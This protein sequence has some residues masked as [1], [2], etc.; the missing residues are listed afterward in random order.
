MRLCTCPIPG[1]CLELNVV[2]FSCGPKRP[3]WVVGLALVSPPATTVSTAD[4]FAFYQ[5]NGV[6][7]M[8]QA[9]VANGLTGVALLIFVA[10]LCSALRRLEGEGSTLLNLLFGTGM[11]VSSL[12]CLEALFTQVLANHIAATGDAAV[13]R[14]LLELNAEIDT[15][16]LLIL[17]MMIGTASLLGLA[18]ECASALACLGWSNRVSSACH[19]Q[20]RTSVHEQC[21]HHRA[22]CLWHR[23][24]SVGNCGKYPHGLARSGCA[25][26]DWIEQEGEQSDRL[27]LGDY[28]KSSLACFLR[29]KGS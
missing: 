27:L 8:W 24:T 11:V 5:A 15:F 13:M 7:A 28:C 4:L 16:K 19:R 6:L 12:S 3:V 17:G 21:F 10:A 26:S 23:S 20:F 18:C 22:V 9:Y 29:L 1:V 14:T 25:K 2:N